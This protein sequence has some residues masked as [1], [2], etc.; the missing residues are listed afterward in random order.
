MSSAV[1]E[2]LLLAQGAKVA[3]EALPSG[4]G[5]ALLR[6]LA[7]LVVVCVLAYVLLRFGLRRLGGGL[8]RT[9]HV[10][11]LE[12]C[13]LGSGK[14]LWVV[15]VG[16]RCFLVGAAEQGLS[17]LAELTPEELASPEEDT[18]TPTAAGPRFATVFARV[19]SRKPPTNDKSAQE[20]D[21]AEKS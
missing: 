7:A 2:V 10:R 12:R 13:P 8:P 21:D 18:K 6:M 9:S 1:Y 19:L 15:R 14:A 3:P 4:Y 17:L 16:A 11:V 20:G 5:S